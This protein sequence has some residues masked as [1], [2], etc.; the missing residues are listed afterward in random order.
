MT[1]FVDRK[2]MLQYKNPLVTCQLFGR[3]LR[4]LQPAVGIF[5][6]P[7]AIE[8]FE[9]GRYQVDGDGSP[10]FGS[11]FEHFAVIFQCMQPGPGQQGAAAEGIAV[12]GLVHMP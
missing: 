12:V 11:G 9:Q 4:Q 1:L 7:V 6:V 10:A 3:P 2:K 8:L 5:I